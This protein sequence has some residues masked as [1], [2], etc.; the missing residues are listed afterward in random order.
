MC[1]CHAFF[2][3]LFW[4]GQGVSWGGHSNIL[5]SMFSIT[6]CLAGC[7]SQSEATVYRCLWLRTILR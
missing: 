3:S 2:M 4:F 7:G 5:C 1:C 6:V